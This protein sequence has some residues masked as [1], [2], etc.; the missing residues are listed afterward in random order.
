LLVERGEALAVLQ[1][2]GW[3]NPDITTPDLPALVRAGLPIDGV[4]QDVLAAARLDQQIDPNAPADGDIDGDLTLAGSTSVTVVAVAGASAQS[5]CVTVT[6]SGADPSLTLETTG[7][8]AAAT[9]S[10]PTEG[11]YVVRLPG[12][13]E[14][15][16]PLGAAEVKR[17]VTTLPAGTRL[18]IA[19]GLPAL[20]LCGVR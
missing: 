2:G 12:A 20:Q 14:R 4:P 3:L 13:G 19:L 5:G 17:L 15:A 6:A 1:P 10:S 8:R 9:I 18:S 11:R 7:G 16:E